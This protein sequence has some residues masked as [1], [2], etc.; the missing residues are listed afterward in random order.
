MVNR[1]KP[2]FMMQDYHS[3]RILWNGLGLNLDNLYNYTTLN[4]HGPSVDHSNTVQ[5]NG[6]FRQNFFYKKHVLKQSRIDEDLFL[7]PKITRTKSHVTIN[8]LINTICSWHHMVY[9]KW[10]R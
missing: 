2:K 8:I 4:V 6:L 3:T 5:T 9:M 7:Y 10:A 1:G